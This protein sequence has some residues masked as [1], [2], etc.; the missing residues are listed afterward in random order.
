MRLICELC[1]F[2]EIFDASLWAR[3]LEQLLA[4]NMVFLISYSGFFTTATCVERPGYGAIAIACLIRYWKTFLMDV[5]TYMVDVEHHHHSGCILMYSQPLLSNSKSK[6]SLHSPS[7]SSL[8]A[9]IFETC[10]DN[11]GL[12]FWTLEC[13]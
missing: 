3:L 11:L 4:M 13:E 7:F 10:V 9:S 8:S 5:I 12:P 6:L 2:Y 1:L